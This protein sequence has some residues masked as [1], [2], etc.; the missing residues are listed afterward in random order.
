[1]K[2]SPNTVLVLKSLA[3]ETRLSI[4]RNI[5]RRNSTVT[6]SDIIDGCGV[7]LHLSQPTM[8][9]HFAKLVVAQVL[10]E[11]KRGVEKYY[12]LNTPLLKQCGINTEKL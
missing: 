9:H 5:A 11:E 4:V 1:M 6:S 10:L 8:S 12:R 7:V 3:D 2:A